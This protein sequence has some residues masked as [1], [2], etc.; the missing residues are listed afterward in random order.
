MTRRSIGDAR[1]GAAVEFA[2]VA[3]TFLMFLFL[4][5]DGGRMMFA[6]QALY[7]LASASARCAAVNATTCPLTGST[8]VSDWAAARGKA[9]SNLA[10]DRT[11]VTVTQ[12]TTATAGVC[13]GVA[14]MMKSTITMPFKKGAMMLLPQ[15]VAPASLVA[16]ACFPTSS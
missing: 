2:L 11:M 9:R 14:G 1:G 15:A 16:T 3:P 4:L 6:K 8:T 13:G 12:V 5:L 10:L 7:E